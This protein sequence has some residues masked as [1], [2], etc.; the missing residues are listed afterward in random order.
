MLYTSYKLT[1]EA[2]PL[3]IIPNIRKSL[4]AIWQNLRPQISVLVLSSRWHKLQFWEQRPLSPIDDCLS[5]RRLE[6]LLSTHAM[7][8]FTS[9]YHTDCGLS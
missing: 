2:L 7:R 9:L 1:P 6:E 5:H 3:P 4:V 8:F